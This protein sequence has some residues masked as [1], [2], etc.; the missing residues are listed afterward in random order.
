MGIVKLED[1]AAWEAKD[2]RILCDDC[3][4]EGTHDMTPIAEDTY[5]PDDYAVICD[6]CKKRLV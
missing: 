6:E 3:A 5:D 2:G 1:V 4:G